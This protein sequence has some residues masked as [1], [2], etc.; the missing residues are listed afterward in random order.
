MWP[1]LGGR[2]W[3]PLSARPPTTSAAALVDAAMSAKPTVILHTDRT[4]PALEVLRGVQRRQQSHSWTAAR[5]EPIEGKTVLVIG[6]GKTG[7]ATARRAQ[8]MGMTTLGIRA[9]PKPMSGVDEVHGPDALL[10]LLPHA[11][12]IV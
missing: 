8:A 2:R 5:L 4:A 12:F 11:D 9:R 6:L 10:A 3:W 7:E 1:R